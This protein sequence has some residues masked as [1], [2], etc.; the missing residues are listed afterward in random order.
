MG[1]ERE[2]L[3]HV[4]RNLAIDHLRRESRVKLIE[5]NGVVLP[6]AE[7]LLS[8]REDASLLQDSI[9]RLKPAEREVVRLKFQES[10]SYKEISA[11]TGHSVSYVG[12]LVHQAVEK[13]R[14][15]MATSGGA[16]K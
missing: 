14:Q 13:L 10:M 8:I 9:G 16:V 1:R 2:W 15:W 6:A 5:E 11:V 7:E 12:V 4:C 3:F